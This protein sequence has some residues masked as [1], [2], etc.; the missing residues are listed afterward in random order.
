MSTDT[1]I[2]N[3]TW[4]TTKLLLFELISNFR[5][6]A[7]DLKQR[8]FRNKFNSI[9]MIPL[10]PSIN[11]SLIGSLMNNNGASSVTEEQ[12]VSALESEQQAFLNLVET[13]GNDVVPLG[14][15]EQAGGEDSDADS[16]A[17]S[18]GE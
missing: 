16:A 9:K 5:S 13:I 2:K 1:K 7:D 18:D 17:A 15:T 11:P 6:R 10:W 3:F 8:I 4:T 12:E 14:K